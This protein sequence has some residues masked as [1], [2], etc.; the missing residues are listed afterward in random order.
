[1]NFFIGAF[2]DGVYL[3]GMTLAETL[4]EG[5]NIRDGLSITKKMWNRTFHGKCIMTTFL[6]LY[7]DFYINYTYQPPVAGPIQVC[8]YLHALLFIQVLQDMC[9]LTTMATEMRTIQFW[10]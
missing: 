8:L 5:G 3:L 10:T 4:A 7:I 9:E 1:V 2:Y 6:Y